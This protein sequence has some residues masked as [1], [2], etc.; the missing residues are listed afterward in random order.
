MTRTQVSVCSCQCCPAC[1]LPSNI[2]IGLPSGCITT[3]HRSLT[4]PFFGRRGVLEAVFLTRL[5]AL[6]WNFHAS[7]TRSRNDA[8]T[9]TPPPLSSFLGDGRSF[10]LTRA[11][12]WGTQASA[13]PPL[14]VLS[15][16]FPRLPFT[17]FV[18]RPV[19]PLF[20]RARKIKDIEI[21]PKCHLIAMTSDGAL[22][23][24]IKPTL[25]PPIPH[26]SMV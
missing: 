18:G 4:E 8:T 6:R 25:S 11:V 2:L 26:T 20:L 9:P 19:G 5:P 21:C 16:R 10:S 7:C 3:Q 24:F 23:L 22:V 1:S 15:L 14:P 13:F 17:N 12:L